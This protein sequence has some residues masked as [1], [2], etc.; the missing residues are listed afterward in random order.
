MCSGP[1]NHVRWL[2]SRHLMPCSSLLR[3]LHTCAH[4]DK[5][6][7]IIK[8]KEHNGLQL[9]EI[10]LPSLCAIMPSKLAYFSL[11]WQKVTF[12]NK[13]RNSTNVK[14]PDLKLYKNERKPAIVLSFHHVHP[15]GQAQAI[16]L[17]SR[18]LYTVSC[19][20]RERPVNFYFPDGSCRQC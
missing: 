11:L 5:I 7:D 1:S 15:K 4:R 6:N 17:G 9:T 8:L 16:V 13:P 19:P 3:Q 2:S 10:P 12:E 18:H 14:L 20:Q